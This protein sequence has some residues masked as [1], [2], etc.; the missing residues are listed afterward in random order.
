MAARTSQ[1]SSHRQWAP[2][3]VLFGEAG[4]RYGYCVAGWCA[5]GWAL[6]VVRGALALLCLVTSDPRGVVRWVLLAG[7]PRVG[8][9][10]EGLG[11]GCSWWCASSCPCGASLPSDVGVVVAVPLLFGVPVGVWVALG[12]STGVSVLRVL[13]RSAGRAECGCCCFAARGVRAC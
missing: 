8:V 13:V 9:Q 1:W 6:L 11:C 7:P 10:V 12:L 3:H 4:G 5:V 2:A